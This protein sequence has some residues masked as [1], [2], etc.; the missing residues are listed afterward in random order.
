MPQENDIDTI[1]LEKNLFRNVIC[2]NLYI[3]IV[4]IHIYI[5][6]FVCNIF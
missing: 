6:V 2:V 3:C 4:Y 5:Q 1:F